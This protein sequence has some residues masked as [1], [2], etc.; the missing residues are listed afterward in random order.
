MTTVVPGAPKLIQAAYLGAP[1][2]PR[3]DGIG[4]CENITSIT[5][6]YIK[7]EQYGGSTGDGVYIKNSVGEKLDKH[8]NKKTH[9]N[10]DDMHAAATVD[11]NMRK[12]T[13]LPEFDFLNKI[14][15][16][17]SDANGFI[18]YGV[19]YDRFFKV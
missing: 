16:I 2:C 15:D 8:H 18:N 19:E 11:T 6:D 9:H 3:G 10:W 13:A 4:L 1:P 5:D 14:T 12:P 17:I 7:P